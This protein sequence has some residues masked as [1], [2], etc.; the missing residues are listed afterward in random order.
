MLVSRNRLAG[1]VVGPGRSRGCVSFMLV[2]T[3]G[4]FVAVVGPGI[5]AAKGCGVTYARYTLLRVVVYNNSGGDATCATGRRVMS[6]FAEND[7]R[8]QPGGGWGCSLNADARGNPLAICLLPGR[9]HT[10]NASIVDGFVE[11][12]S[13]HNCGT[14]RQGA[15]NGYTFANR[16]QGRDHVPCSVARYLALHFFSGGYS[17]HGLT[18]NYA[19][20]GSGNIYWDWTCGDGSPGDR[21]GPP[22]LR[23]RSIVTKQ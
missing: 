16:V 17:H 11:H 23:G 4:L 7:L 15:K 9:G 1:F 5:A 8:G 22:V 10:L 19:P 14:V 18:C 13:G 12:T 3:V 6:R 2:V 20:M 21:W